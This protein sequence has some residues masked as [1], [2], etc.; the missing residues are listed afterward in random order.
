MELQLRGNHATS[1]IRTPLIK[2]KPYSFSQYLSISYWIKKAY[3]NGL[4]SKK[5][6]YIYDYEVHKNKEWYHE[7]LADTGQYNEDLDDDVYDFDIRM[8]NAYRCT[9]STRTFYSNCTTTYVC[10]NVNFIH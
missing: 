4:L 2:N 5:D 1:H 6:M 10:V 7:L 8:F 3:M 9:S